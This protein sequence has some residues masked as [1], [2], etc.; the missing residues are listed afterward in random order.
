MCGPPGSGHFTPSVL[1][2]GH[3]LTQLGIASILPFYF[4]LWVEEQPSKEGGAH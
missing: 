2:A 3:Q 4:H 1:C